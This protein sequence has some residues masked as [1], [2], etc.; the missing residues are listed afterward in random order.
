L[1][2]TF[3]PIGDKDNPFTGTFDGKGFT[4]SGLN[5]SV[6]EVNENAYAG[7]FRWTVGA[8]IKNL[9]IDDSVISAATS[10]TGEAHTSS[11]AYAGAVVGYAHSTTIKDCYSA[12]TVTSQH[13]LSAYAGGIIGFAVGSEMEN[14]GNTGKVSA[15][16]AIAYAGGIA[17]LAAGHRYDSTIK[18][19]YN[20]G[21]VTATG[22]G[23]AGGIA[24]AAVNDAAGSGL[25][26]AIEECYN[27]GA[28]TAVGVSSAAGGI[29]GRM[30]V[31][32]SVSNCYNVATITS[33][34]DA[35]GI[36]GYVVGFLNNPAVIENCY[37]AAAVT[38]GAGGYS[39]GIVGTASNLKII[40][41]YFLTGK[42]SGNKTFGSNISGVVVDG[43]T[44]AP[45]QA[46]GAKSAGSMKQTLEQA[47][48]TGSIYYNWDFRETAGSIWTADAEK[49]NG[50][51]M[52]FA[53]KDTVKEWKESTGGSD[54]IPTTVLIVAVIAVL[55]AAGAAVWF[56]VL[57]K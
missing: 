24:G 53:L 5:I 18:G 20:H 33:G 42:V 51:P 49:N 19:C 26:A 44:T 57:R 1:T 56:F 22:A 40:H 15:T 7:L 16:G 23:V 39:G 21:A 47:Q 13:P 35:G 46:S 52:L 17:G 32:S 45:N 6:P 54:G 55:G 8:E 36:A 9:K 14:C 50:Y 31:S 11:V 28:I 43:G 4:I 25:D 41:C 12:A 3:T 48:T 30:T 29:A 10:L 37:N 34:A 38:G 27:A 2:G